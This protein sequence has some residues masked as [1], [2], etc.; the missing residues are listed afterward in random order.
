MAIQILSDHFKYFFTRLNPSQTFQSVASSQYNSIKGLIEDRYGLAANL[1]PKCFL[2]GSYGQ[3]TAIYTINDVDIVTLCNLWQPP[4]GG[5]RTKTYD[6]TE[7]FNA[8]A[9]PLLN[10]YRYKNVSGVRS[11]QLDN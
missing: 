7:I 6:R 2:Q 4:A 1:S 8:I 9:S 11:G 10:D 5:P 3:E